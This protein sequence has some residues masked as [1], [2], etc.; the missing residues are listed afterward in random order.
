MKMVLLMSFLVSY[1]TLLNKRVIL[2]WVTINN[3]TSNAV[4]LLS[5]SSYSTSREGR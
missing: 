1:F 5:T 3:P 2:R 4:I